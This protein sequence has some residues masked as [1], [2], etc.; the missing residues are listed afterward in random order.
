MKTIICFIFFLFGIVSLNVFSFVALQVFFDVKS[1]SQSKLFR[2]F[3]E[4]RKKN[5]VE[6]IINSIKI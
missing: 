6:T 2:Q 5:N 1:D 3:L 4:E